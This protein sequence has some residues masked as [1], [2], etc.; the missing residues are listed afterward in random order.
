MINVG[1]AQIN[2]TTSFDTNMENI[3]K[4]LS[5]FS[6]T[7]ADLVVFPEC[8]LSGFSAK[9]AEATGKALT[10]Y[11]DKV[12]QWSIDNN[13]AV[14][15]PSAYKVNDEIFNSGFFFK[16]QIKEQFYKTG[17]TES[18]KTFFSVPPNYEKQVFEVAGHKFIPLICLEAQLEPFKY[19]PQGEVGFILWPGYWGWE[20]GDQW[21][22]LKKDNSPNEVYKNCEKWKVPLLQANFAKNV[23]DDGRSDGPHG[24]GFVINS[25]NSVAY[26]ASF[27]SQECILVSMIDGKVLNVKTV[28]ADNNLQNINQSNCQ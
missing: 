28:G 7:K 3:M 16:G 1:L 10:P 24:L 6:N 15:L 14:L 12:Q 9:I 11:L 26:Q 13:K 2:N 4:C 18:E 25:D 22:E 8:S 27:E 23:L 20:E 17:L 5:V 21:H 19:F